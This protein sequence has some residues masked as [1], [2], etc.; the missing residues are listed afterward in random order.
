LASGRCG[1]LCSGGS[2]RGEQHQRRRLLPGNGLW[3]DILV[4]RRRCGDGCDC[5]SS[6]R[7]GSD[8][9]CRE[10]G[11]RTS[12]WTGTGAGFTPRTFSGHSSC[13]VHS[14]PV[15]RRNSDAFE[16]E[17]FTTSAQRK[18]PKACAVSSFSLQNCF[19]D[20]GRAS[21]PPLAMVSIRRPMS[22]SARQILLPGNSYVLD[23]NQSCRNIVHCQVGDTLNHPGRIHL[24][25]GLD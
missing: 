14:G 7:S 24:R 3:Q 4:L 18:R 20:T 15:L 17:H 1:V 22:S 11:H 16:R 19:T 13:H 8:Y 21:R 23:L 6:H 12:N 10:L 2:G 25:S 5:Q 9:Q